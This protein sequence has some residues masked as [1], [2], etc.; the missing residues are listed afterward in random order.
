MLLPRLLFVCALALLGACSSLAIVIPEPRSSPSLAAP[1]RAVPTEARIVQLA[2]GR[3]AHFALCEDLCPEPTPK[4]AWGPAPPITTL[5]PPPGGP[6]ETKDRVLLLFSVGQTQLTQAHVRALRALR[7]SVTAA[8][9]VE[10]VGRT[11]SHG[12]EATNDAIARARADS[13]YRFL[14][15]EFP[16]LEGKLTSDAAGSCCYAAS[17]DSA[18]SRRQNRRVEVVLTSRGGTKEPTP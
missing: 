15:A 17:N 13:V 6:A 4:S 7:A 16:L 18:D 12:S 14:R 5:A 3:G 8:D 2:Y 11:D 10:V 1:Q 9:A